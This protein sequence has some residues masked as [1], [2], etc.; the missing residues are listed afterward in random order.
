M[1]WA[2]WGFRRR[3]PLWSSLWSHPSC[4]KASLGRL[5]AFDPVLLDLAIQRRPAQAEQA[6]RFGNVAVGALEGL[7]DE[8]AL[9][10]VDPQRF[11]LV[12]AHGVAE[13]QVVG[14][15]DVPLA[16][17]DGAVDHIA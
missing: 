3:H 17:D 14:E 12:A 1:A 15:D 4:A 10:E 2:N 5:F 7:L 9:P 8:L 13:A 11:E 6:G 16:H